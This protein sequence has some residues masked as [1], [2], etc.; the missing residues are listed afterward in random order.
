MTI[1]NSRAALIGTLKAV[2]AVR[3]ADISAVTAKWLM[4]ALCMIALILQG[5]LLQPK[6]WFWTG[7]M[8]Y[9][10][11]LMAEIQAGEV[12]PGG[13]YPGMPAFYS[14]LL[15]WMSAGIGL[16]TGVRL[17]EAI[18]IVS[19][20][21]APLLPLASYWTGR[22]LGLDRRSAVVGALLATFAGGW[23]TTE[24]RVW[25]DSLFVGQHNF[26]PTFPR[27]IAF[28]LLPVGLVCVHR[29]V[30]QR[31]RPGA[32]LAGIVFALMVLA[33]T[34]T[35]VF[36]A[37]L[38]ALYLAFLLSMRRDLFW[39]A[40]R[41]SII[42]SALTAGL[43]A[44]WWV[45]ELQAIIASQSFSVEMPAYRV[46]V[47]LSLSEFPMEFG[48]FLV[49][50]P[51][52]LFMTAR[53]FLR[54]RDPGALLL[55]VWWTAPVLLAV[56]RPT[57]FPGGDTFFPRRLWQ[58]SSQPLVLMAAQALVIG[59]LPALRI[60][61]VLAVGLVAAV[62]LVSTVP[63][64]RG[65]WDRIADFW[66]EPEFVDQEWD[67]QGNFA[68][69]PWL[70]REARAHGPR[71]VLSPVTEA[72][73]IWYEAGQKVVYLHR[74]AA[75]KLAFDVG[76]L[77][78]FSEAERQSDV[79]R[80][81]SGDPS[82][83]KE[84]ALKYSSPYIVMKRSESR[85]AGIE[86]TAR[87]LAPHGEGRGIGRLVTSN[88]YEFLT[89][90]ANDQTR[91]AIWSPSDRDA[92]LVLR[93][94]RRGRGSVTPGMLIVNGRELPMTDAELPRDNWAD[95][96]RVVELRQGTNVVELRAAQSLEVL[97][98]TGYALTTADLLPGWSAAYEDA[99]YMVLVPSSKHVE[100]TGS[101]LARHVNRDWE[102]EDRPVA[103]SAS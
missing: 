63:A 96:R 103:P 53:R 90:G 28:L 36:A 2:A 83:L 102:S 22:C 31:W 76:R 17:T 74:T 85:L 47:K 62:C 4:L 5:G 3:Q 7:D 46:P 71:T 6:T 54:Q 52:G 84:T 25:V 75:I 92:D 58:F 12:M 37:P 69:G 27:D 82:A 57:G 35:A 40:V 55:L 15:H 64:S 61:G 23:K 72:T 39:P 42:T 1:T 19:I 11:A 91:F 44:F 29:A 9:H 101:L 56:L 60:R 8:I 49:L 43:S 16:V 59:V 98:L 50:G 97:R 77:S 95:I 79:L 94:K 99:F 14:P 33:H 66:N 38:L 13:P 20:L 86:L 21:F 65:T 80:A 30:V 68:M 41:V 48:L 18:R 87:G 26:F 24:D 32:W 10:H 93:V 81:Y 34:Q 67:L 89:M 100:V 51:I 45:W 70:A 73:L 78:G 88:H